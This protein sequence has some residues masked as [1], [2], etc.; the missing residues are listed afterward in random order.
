MADPITWRNVT[1]PSLAEAARPLAYAQTSFS[2]G[3]DALGNALKDFQT[4]QKEAWKLQDMDATNAER[5]A[6]YGAKTPEELAAL[7]ASGALGGVVAANGARI[8]RAALDP[9]IDARP[10]VLQKQQ[11]EGWQFD[12]DKLMQAEMPTISAARAAFAN[13]DFKGAQAFI[14]QL[15]P[16]NRAVVA[17]EMLKTSMEVGKYDREGRKLDE[18]ISHWKRA[19]ASSATQA[20]AAAAQAA[21]HKA[22]VD[23]QAQE[24]MEK[25]YTELV[26]KRLSLAGTG[27]S[28]EGAK[29]VSDELAKVIKDPKELAR[30]TQ[31]AGDIASKNPDASPTA[32]YN[33]VIGS[34]DP[35]KGI[36][37]WSNT[38]DDAE[39]RLKSA[40][41]NESTSEAKQR[42]RE[43][44]AMVDQ[45]IDF[46]ARQ[47]K[48][49]GVPKATPGGTP[50]A[51][52]P[53]GKPGAPAAT[54]AAAAVPAMAEP[55]NSPF[56]PKLREKEME[57]RLKIAQGGMK[58]HSPEVKQ[59]QAEEA[60]MVAAQQAE[61]VDQ[62]L[63]REQAAI[64]AQFAPP[65]YETPYDR[66]N[67]QRSL[68][69]ALEKARANAVTVDPQVAA[70]RAAAAKLWESIKDGNENAGAA[71]ADVGLMVPRMAL[72]A[73]DTAVI[74]PLRAAG[75]P[76]G[77]TAPLLTPNGVSTGSL[78]P[79]TDVKRMRKTLQEE[80]KKKR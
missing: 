66:M 48:Y 64:R 9:V 3:F 15:S 32:I 13:K 52:D 73:Y 68:E 69:V 78:T 75:V 21:A 42:R 25:R 76:V 23:F 20:N 7:R 28:Q 70:D 4:Q 19:D 26:A 65:A 34:Q 8:D 74:R 53:A 50:P 33:A 72:S 59:A 44:V 55:A 47:L 45:Q 49:P 17:G 22:Q 54:G 71:I 41:A 5:A 77:N 31:V 60:K 11:T 6:I 61:T 14:D 58:D 40:L 10:G 16:E 12:R 30:A 35:A 39:A 79:F 37:W 2:S 43:A 57:E 80:A 18:E 62:R 36:R 46:A 29:F 67:R 56:T 51:A 63:A 24:A 38:G 1:G 27:S